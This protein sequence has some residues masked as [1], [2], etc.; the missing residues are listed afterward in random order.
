LF[1]I[2]AA[3]SG[4]EGKNGK[5]KRLGVA[6][7]KN[8]PDGSSFELE[9]LGQPRYVRISENK[10]GW[11]ISTWNKDDG[12]H[13]HTWGL[14]YPDEVDEAVSWLISGQDVTEKMAG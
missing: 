12:F 1:S 9:V 5:A 10:L 14:N 7:V 3:K 4:R 11:T 2:Q 13:V 6:L 8:H